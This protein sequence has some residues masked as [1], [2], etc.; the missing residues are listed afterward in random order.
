MRKRFRSLLLLLGVG[1]LG[2]LVMV[3]RPH[4]QEIDDTS[5]PSVSEKDLQMYIDVYTA[6]Q[7]D[8]DLTIDNAIKPFN[9]PL[10]DFRQTERRIQGE[11][12]LVERVRDA[13]LAHAKEHSAFALAPTATPKS[14][15]TPKAKKDHPAKTK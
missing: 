7:D 3:F 11:P 13:L 4:A 10:D 14:G 6:M 2:V 5:T 9:V 1:L 8:H 12:R 15:P